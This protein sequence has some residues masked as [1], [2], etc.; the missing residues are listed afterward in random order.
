MKTTTETKPQP[1]NKM[2]TKLIALLALAAL[3]AFGSITTPISNLN[4]QPG[5]PGIVG[6][7]V[8]SDDSLASSF[9]TGSQAT[10]LSSV[11][12]LASLSYA[13]NNPPGDLILSLYSNSGSAP[14]SSLAILTGSNPNTSVGNF[15]P[16]TFTYSGLT[17][18]ADNTTYCIVASD[19]TSDP[20]Y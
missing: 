7:F 13:G 6:G 8:D 18:L 2:K 14:G 5:S 20:T 19:P 11:T 4:Q 16:V 10:Y 12:I 1:K 9:T 15:V 3:P 17:L